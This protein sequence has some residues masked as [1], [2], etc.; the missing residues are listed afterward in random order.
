MNVFKKWFD[1][2]PYVP[3]IMQEVKPQVVDADL[4]KLTEESGER[5]EKRAQE[6]RSLALSVVHLHDD[7]LKVLGQRA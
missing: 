6:S 1:R 5:I 3:A 2:H 4:A 7:L